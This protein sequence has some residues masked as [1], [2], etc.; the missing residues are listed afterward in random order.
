MPGTTIFGSGRYVP[1]KPVSSQA[2]S[3]V[4]D[5]S[6]DWILQRTGIEQRYFAQ[7]G[8]GVSDL[9]V[10]ASLAALEAAGLEPSD[11]DYILF[12]TMTP[13]YA[14]PGSGALLGQK[15]GLAG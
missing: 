5:T 14:F 12:N 6:G 15:L 10:P 13:D 9:A 11:I 7:E 2:L 8:V 1:G 3:R 4:M